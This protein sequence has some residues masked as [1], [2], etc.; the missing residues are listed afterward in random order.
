MKDQIKKFVS[1]VYL[2]AYCFFALLYWLFTSTRDE[3]EDG[4]KEMM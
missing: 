3:L 4:A 2:I 1:E